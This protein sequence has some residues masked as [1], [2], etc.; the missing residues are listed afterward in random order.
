MGKVTITEINDRLISLWEQYV[1]ETRKALIPLFQQEPTKNCLLFVG[2]NPSFN[3][4]DMSRL[5]EQYLRLSIDVYTYFRWV[6][7]REIDMA[8]LAK[9]DQVSKQHHRYFGRCREMSKF[10][11]I[12]WEHIDL[13]FWRETSQAELRHV[14]FQN[15]Q[16]RALNEFG[17]EQLELAMLLLELVM[18]TCVVVINALASDLYKRHRSLKFSAS[19]GCYLDY[20]AGRETPVFLSGMLTGQRAIDRFSYERLLWHVARELRKQYG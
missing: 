8:L 10:L 5:I 7:R 4:A 3:P 2:L 6:L 14:L 15:W 1:P 12:P 13:L 9:M 19:R 16:K 11:G 20:I 18:P 17:Q